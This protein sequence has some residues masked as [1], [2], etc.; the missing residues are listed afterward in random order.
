MERTLNEYICLK[1]GESFFTYGKTK[2]RLC[3]NCVKENRRLSNLKYY[4]EH[5][6]G[7][8]ITKKKEKPQNLL[9]IM[10]ELNKY[11]EEHGTFL[12][13]GK[14]VVLTSSENKSIIK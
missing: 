8:K 13:Y 1:C 7:V 5:C 6:T 4:T 10:A 12:T 9:E 11:N 14:Y 3:D 2:R